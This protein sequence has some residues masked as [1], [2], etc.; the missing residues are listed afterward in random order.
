VITATTEKCSITRNSSF[1][2]KVNIPGTQRLHQPNNDDE[3]DDFE[4]PLPALQQAAEQGPTQ[5]QPAIIDNQTPNPVQRRYPQRHDR[6]PPN[7][8]NDFTT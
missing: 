2:K 4:F 6:R 8:L 3:D 1:F 5:R 7:R